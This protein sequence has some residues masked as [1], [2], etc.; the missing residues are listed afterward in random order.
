MGQ[1]KLTSN[2]KINYEK[3]D[4]IFIV[5]QIA[6]TDFKKLMS[7]DTCADIDEEHILIMVYNM[8]CALK[9]LHSAGII[10]RDIKPGNVLVDENCN[11]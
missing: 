9:F 5:M 2:M 1:S 7:S 4:H 10:H 6:D 3:F 11:I 8:L